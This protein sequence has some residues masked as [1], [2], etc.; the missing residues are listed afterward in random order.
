MAIGYS[1]C[2]DLLA[3]PPFPKTCVDGRRASLLQHEAVERGEAFRHEA[4]NRIVA[5]IYCASV[6]KISQH[7]PA[8]L[9]TFP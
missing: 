8:V 5:F 4:H 6:V 9:A 3:P 7:R 1:R 2:H